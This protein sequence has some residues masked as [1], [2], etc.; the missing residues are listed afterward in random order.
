MFKPIYFAITNNVT[1]P[2]PRHTCRSG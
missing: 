1:G 2:F